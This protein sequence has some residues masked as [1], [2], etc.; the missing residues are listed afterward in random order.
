MKRYKILIALVFLFGMGVPA[1]AQYFDWVKS[2]TS[3]ADRAVSHIE[4]AVTD[5]EGNV[6]F[7]GH[8]HKG[9]MIDGE[10]LLPVDGS[11]LNFGT[12]LVKLSPDGQLL[13]HKALWNSR[14]NQTIANMQMVGDSMLVFMGFPKFYQENVFTDMFTYYWD[15]VM[16][17]VPFKRDSVNGGVCSAIIYFNLDGSIKEQHFLNVGY[18]D[19][20]GNPIYR[21]WP[22]VAKEPLNGGSIFAV[23]NEGNVIIVARQFDITGAY[24][25]VSHTSRH[26]TW[27]NGDISAIRIMVDGERSFYV[28]SNSCPRFWNN[29]IMKFSPHFDSLIAA[30]F[31]F[32]PSNTPIGFDPYCI[33]MPPEDPSFPMEEYRSYMCNENTIFESFEIDEENN[34]YLIGSFERS[35]YCC[36]DT[37]IPVDS[38]AGIYL[39]LK[40]IPSNISTA[41]YC[42]LLME[43]YLIKFDPQL[44]AQYLKQLDYPKRGKSIGTLFLHPNVTDS[45]LVVPIHFGTG[46]VSDPNPDK[47][48]SYD[49]DTLPLWLNKS[50]AFLRLDRG[51]GHLLAYGGLHVKGDWQFRCAEHD[52]GGTYYS[53]YAA[54][55][56][57]FASGIFT[58]GDILFN[59][60]L[61]H[62]NIREF[63]EEVSALAIWDYS[64]HEILYM[65][66]SGVDSNYRRIN[67]ALFSDSSLYIYGAA[68]N[69]TLHLGDLLLDARNGGGCTTAFIARYVDTAF[70]RPYVYVPPEIPPEPEDIRVLVQDDMGCMT[71]YPNP[72]RQ[73][74]RVRYKGEE[75]LREAYLTDMAGRRETVTLVPCGEGEWS[76]D[77]AHLPPAPY[78]LTLVTDSGRQITARLS[79]VK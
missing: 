12:C 37:V 68:S 8:F 43:S 10:D 1:E 17:G 53:T 48:F 33:N 36:T 70:L 13:W 64:G 56:N 42:T 5:S 51:D 29:L 63:L 72:F 27:E 66:L 16:Q 57:R 39:T 26:Y 74:V 61:H 25:P 73:R 30:R 69:M 9:A 75:R 49:G 50:A 14:D 38:A 45:G 46:S 6:Y 4:R 60:S 18:N 7:L 71:V 76:V 41:N 23:D 20:A 24:D 19:T 31:L 67:G 15:T 54:E 77:F 40:M 62:Y 22:V 65:E 44:R 2:Y 32:E 35:I 78:L 58:K 28:H 21:D 59:D 34:I 55:N 79:R 11:W 47:Y 3:C 52:K